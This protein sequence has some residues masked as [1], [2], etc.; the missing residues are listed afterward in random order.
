MCE[1][2]RGQTDKDRI[3]GLEWLTQKVIRELAAADGR[4][5][6]SCCA[7]QPTDTLQ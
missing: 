4:S 6:K 7:N 1:K 5:A 2:V 3:E